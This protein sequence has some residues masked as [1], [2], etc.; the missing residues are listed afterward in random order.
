MALSGDELSGDELADE[1]LRVE[2]RGATFTGNLVGRVGRLT[3]KKATAAPMTIK[4]AGHHF[5]S[6]LCTAFSTA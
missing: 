2:N 3:A 5:N 4:I 1:A 6:A